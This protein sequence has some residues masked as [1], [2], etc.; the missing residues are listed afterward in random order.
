MQMRYFIPERLIMK[1]MTS[2]SSEL[3]AAKALADKKGRDIVII[4]I[5]LKASFADYFVI[6]S[7]GSERQIEA[8][9]DEVDDKMA[10]AGIE[11][12]GREGKNTSGWILMDFGDVIVNVMTEEMRQKYNIEKVWGDCSFTKYEEGNE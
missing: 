12:K 6:A 5:G 10:E 1:T 7:G 9:A 8:L 2:S 4:E 3:I 11:L